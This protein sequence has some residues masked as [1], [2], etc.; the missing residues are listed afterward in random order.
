M[1]RFSLVRVSLFV[2]FVFAAEGQFLPNSQ[3]KDTAKTSLEKI[4]HSITIYRDKWG[5]PHVYGPTDYSVMFGFMYAQAEDNFWQ[6]EDSYIQA[7]GRAAEAYGENAVLSANAGRPLESDLINRQLEIN[8]LAQEDYAKLSKQAKDICDAT[9]DGLNYFLEKNP[10]VKPI[11]ITK[12][13]PWHLLAFNRFAQY[14]LF[15]F[16]RLGLRPNELRASV[17]EVGAKTSVVAEPELEKTD[18]IAATP[19]EMFFN[20]PNAAAQIGSNTW[21]IAPKKSATGK[22][23]LLVNPHQPFFGPGQWIEGHVHSDSGW[24]MSGASF[25]GSP[26]PTL[27]H[28]DNLGWSH[29]VNA[30]DV[31]DAWEE[32][33][34]DT[35]HPLNYKYG[36]GYKSATEWSETIKVK[37][38]T[39]IVE[40]TFKM[41][42]T[43]HGPVMAV[44]DGKPLAVR[45]A[46]WENA[47][48]ALEQRY[49]MSKAKNLK[50]FKA[51]MS[52]LAVPMFNTMYADREGNIFYI[53]YGAVPKR[54]PKYDWSKFVEGSDP[55]TEWQG[56]HSLEELPQIL[57][58]ASG[59]AQ[60]CNA[61]PLLASGEEFG[62][63]GN[64]DGAKFPA[65]MVTEK[66]NPRSRI[67][68]RVLSE[69]PKFTYEDW[70]KAAYDT[71]VIEAERLIPQL[72][73]EFDKFK[74]A[75]P[76]KAEKLAEV[77]A[78]LKGWNGVS[79]I[80]SVPMTVFTLY[81]YTRIQPQAQQL[82]K[83]R[84]YPEVDVL[85]Y[86]VNDLTKKLGTWKVK[87]G[88]LMRIQRV[89]T[90]GVLEP[91]SDAKPSLPV[92]GGPGDPVGIVFN[93]YAP[94]ARGQKHRYGIA[95]HSFFSVIEFGAK[96][97]ARSVLQFGQSADPKSKHYFDQAELYSKMQF[98]PAWFALEEIKANL[99]TS[100]HPGEKAAAAS[101]SAK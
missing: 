79:T 33:F 47:G 39:G 56:Y 16:R 36:N 32:K 4:A 34:D 100:Y 6:I 19:M 84:P 53:Y 7:I 90:S 67:S 18:F 28:N 10:Q 25:P 57:N 5:V 1:K 76:A 21:A 60:N 85:D 70:T 81:A 8:R 23:M 92:A 9:A 13:E 78:M 35:S 99:E 75:D 51:A 11:L 48:G 87:W 58:P 38:D 94:E 80:D 64:P 41:R 55:G 71:R 31:I 26:F 68:R 95:G 42:K 20:D 12:F 45:M 63:D 2:L 22:A 96:P 44:R 29:T 77:I 66:D 54:D 43:H 98:K 52:H 3:A 50:E 83:G 17:Q 27:G 59:F 101:A 65:Y 62:K 37:T 46:A 86:V 61:T 14:Q 74:A 24:N 91:F 69:R 49:L 73:T 93:F 30:P 15:I 88:D 40:R 89:Q 72:T 82:T 97:Q